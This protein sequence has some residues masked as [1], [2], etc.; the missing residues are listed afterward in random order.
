MMREGISVLMSVYKKENSVYFEKALNSVLNQTLTPDEIVIVQDGELT[1]EL[2]D[3]IQRYK[4]KYSIIRTYEFK[5][6]VMLGRALEKGVILCEY[7]YIARM[8]TDDIAVKDRLEN[9]YNYLKAHGD[10]S[11][12][13]GN[14]EE[15]NDDRSYIQVKKMP[16]GMK[17]IRRY[18]KYRNPINHMSVMFRRSAV[19]KSGNYRHFP[20]LEDYDLWIRMMANG[21]RFENLDKVLVYARTNDDIY[22]R[23]GGR[24]YY[25]Q[26]KKLRLSEHRLGLT[27]GIEYVL[28]IVASFAMTMQPASFRRTIYRNLLRKK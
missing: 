7:E 26:Y 2:Y 15:F 25:K 23:R 1:D 18:G 4:E 6:N 3:I 24:A 5:E 11:V 19:L 20:Y 8:D 12:L 10:V 21:M 14:I 17:N 16:I 28:S 27:N 13:G 9:Q 22:K